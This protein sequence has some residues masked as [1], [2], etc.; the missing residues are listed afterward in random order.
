[1]LI[2]QV[3]TGLGKK[4]LSPT[5][6]TH[7]RFLDEIT[8]IALLMVDWVE[9]HIQGFLKIKLMQVILQYIHTVSLTFNSLVSNCKKFNEAY[10]G[11]SESLTSFFKVDFLSK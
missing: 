9:M 10:L 5:N 4:L 7:P 3:L 11:L 2:T 6:I 1:M 8:S